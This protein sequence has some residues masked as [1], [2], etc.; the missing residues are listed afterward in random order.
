MYISSLAQSY[1]TRPSYVRNYKD[2]FV[3]EIPKESLK[4]NQKDESHLEDLVSSRTF[5]TSELFNLREQIQSRPKYI[6][7][8]SAINSYLRFQVA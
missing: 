3:L 6:F 4:L 2:S 7:V 8:D 5:S 1:Y